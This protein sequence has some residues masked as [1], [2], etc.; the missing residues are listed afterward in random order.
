MSIP[1]P[2]T[3]KIPQVSEIAIA[4]GEFLYDA[5][6]K[7][8]LK[9]V[10]KALKLGSNP[11]F[12]NYKSSYIKKL[13]EKREKSNEKEKTLVI[14]AED[15]PDVINSLIAG[16]STDNYNH[17]SHAISAHEHGDKA[18]DIIKRLIA[19]GARA[20]A[21]LTSG[22][23]LLHNA[24]DHEDARITRLLVEKGANPNFVYNGE[25]PLSLATELEYPDDVIKELVK[26]GANINRKDEDGN[27]LLHEAVINQDRQRV[28]LL[29]RS[30]ANPNIIN[31]DGDTPLLFASY[32][33]DVSYPIIEVLVSHG[34]DVK[35]VNQYGKNAL[36][37]LLVPS[38]AKAV[39]LLHSKGA[40]ASADRTGLLQAN[41]AYANNS[42][43]AKAHDNI[44]ALLERKTAVNN[45]EKTTADDKDTMSFVGRLKKERDEK[46]AAES[47]IAIG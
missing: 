16:K 3:A 37:M 6:E 26:A 27:T 18:Y 9:A 20:D 33:D 17:I 8:D 47:D 38:N 32:E 29:L 40:H 44:S 4:N 36:D 31:D 15:L 2:D 1:S 24:I 35:Q 5:I 46:R 14:D 43:D 23:S 34:A 22:S 10:D 39:Q 30:G 12:A 7:G 21:L 42:N 19:A 13:E 28:E 41:L 45:N 25:T 11:D